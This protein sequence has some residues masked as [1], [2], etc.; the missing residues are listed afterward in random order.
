MG[1]R[2]PPHPAY[3]A[4]TTARFWQFIRAGLRGMYRRWP[5]RYEALRNARRAKAGGGRQRWEFKCA[6]CKKHFK[7]TEVEVDHVEQ[8]GTLKS[9]DDLPVFVARL[10]CPATK[11]QVLCKPCHKLKTAQ[12]RK[13]K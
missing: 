7:Q 9:Y 1:K 8:A 13:V 5:P 10:F 3:E 11:L 4:W 12:E 6:K 2:T